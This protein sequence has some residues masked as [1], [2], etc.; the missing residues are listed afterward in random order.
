MFRAF[1]LF[2]PGRQ[3]DQ[4]LTYSLVPL[5]LPDDLLVPVLF[6]GFYFLFLVNLI[7]KNV[8][9]VAMA[10]APQNAPFSPH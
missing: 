3:V 1:P 6:Y 2:H 10:Q 5:S 8:N 7:F 4:A 9:Q